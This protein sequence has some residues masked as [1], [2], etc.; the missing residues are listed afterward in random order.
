MNKNIYLHGIGYANSIYYDPR[1]QRELFAI[2]L[3]SGYILS[4]KLQGVQSKCGFNGSEYISLCD[5]EKRD[6]FNGPNNYNTYYG[7]I[8]NS[9]S[10]SF[11]KDKLETIEPIIVPQI[12]QDYYGFDYMRRLGENT[13]NVR[14]SDLPDEVQVKDKISLELMDK[15]TFPVYKFKECYEFRRD[16]KKIK[17]L[18]EEIKML[19][20]IM[21]EFNYDVPIYDIETFNELNDENI[22]SLI[23]KR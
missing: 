19:K 1:I 15:I 16:S 12:S 5:Y 21:H 13:S 2:I 4:T 9:L 17:L 20:N 18:K 14:Y 3:E 23:L 10:F 22:E 8:R 11:P 6:I 7:Y